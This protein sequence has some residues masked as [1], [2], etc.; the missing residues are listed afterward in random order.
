MDIRQLRCFDA[1]LTTGAMTRAAG[2]L[3]LA[4]PT[5]SITIAQL[6]REIGF[7]LF[8]RS[9]GRLEPTPEAYAF[10]DTALQALESVARVAQVADEI[11]R[12][13]EGE[14]SIMCY[15]GI[16]WRF[17]P[18]LVE[19]FR[20]NRKN[21]QVRLISRSSVALRQFT[22]VQNFD[23]AVVETPVLQPRDTIEFFRYRCYCALP[24]GHELAGRKIITPDDLSGLPVATLFP[25]HTT[26]HQI[27]KVFAECGA[28][29]KVVLEC[30]F[31]AS[32]LSFVKAGGGGTIL[33]PITA[34][35]I[36]PGEIV[37][38][39]FEPAIDYEI[40]LLRPANRPRSR[41]A[42]EFCVQLRQKLV[43]LPEC[44]TQR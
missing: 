32:A 42:D 26:N 29:L 37:L 20:S 9:K 40:A 21:I 43:A 24:H 34:A 8:K 17:M 41:L 22:M 38:L 19:Q 6:E 12:L 23:V 15:P 2:Q 28:H 7:T 5:V 33:D 25:E 3:G 11:K 44:Q 30:D 27:R 4:Q 16:A 36:V 18:E 35:Q 39:P 1:V 31:F 13:N 10:H 14:V